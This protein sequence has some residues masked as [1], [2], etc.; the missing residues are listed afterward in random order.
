MDIYQKIIVWALPVLLAITLHEVAHGWVARY[1]GDST[2]AKLGRL[3]LNPIKHI[4]T[5]GTVLVPAIMILLPGNFLF[6]WA[7]PVPVDINKLGSPKRDMSIVAVAGPLSNLVMAI[8]WAWLIKFNISSNGGIA[9]SVVQTLILMGLAGVIIN[10]ILMVL[11]MIPM[12]PLDGGRVLTGLLP[13][14]LSVKFAKIERFGLIIIV[15]LLLTG[16]LNNIMATSFSLSFGL[17]EMIVGLPSI[18]LAPYWDLL[19]PH[20]E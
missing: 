13:D 19:F 20:T 5:I 14:S 17:V 7:K 15:G 16:V 18:E 2:A 4:D 1:L 10:L 12:P 9:S 6:G 8:L 11:N 3:S